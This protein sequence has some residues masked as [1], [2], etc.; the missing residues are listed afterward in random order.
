M[1]KSVTETFASQLEMMS[2]GGQGVNNNSGRH[3]HVE[4]ENCQSNEEDIS[5]GPRTRKRSTINQ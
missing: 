1:V 2:G 3:Y 5:Q 4:A